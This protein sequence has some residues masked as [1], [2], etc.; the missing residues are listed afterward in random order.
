MTPLLWV[1]VQA[2]CLLFSI[3]IFFWTRRIRLRALALVKDAD[4]VGAKVE[5]ARAEV[6]ALMK[7]IH[8]CVMDRA[9]LQHLIRMASDGSK[10]PLIA[11]LLDA[12]DPRA[13]ID[14]HM[15]ASRQI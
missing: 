11:S 9:R 4:E 1:L 12:D 7:D 14:L 15:V 13:A 10:D 8:G 5:T 6:V 2:A 3:I